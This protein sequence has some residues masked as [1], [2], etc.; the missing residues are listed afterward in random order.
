MSKVVYSRTAIQG[1]ID[2]YYSGDFYL[3][4]SG[5]GT[6]ASFYDQER[7]TTIAIAGIG[8]E[9]NSSSGMFTAG[10]VTQLVLNDAEGDKLVTVDGSYKAA[11]LSAAESSS[12]ADFVRVLFAHRDQITGSNGDD[13]LMGFGGK[14][15]I[16]GGRGNDYLDG[17]AGNGDVLNGGKGDDFFAFVAGNGNDTVQN[18]D[19]KGIKDGSEFYDH[20][21][22]YLLTDNYHI[23]KNTDGDAVVVLD[24]TN[25]TLTLEG[26]SKADLHGYNFFVSNPE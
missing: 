9:G 10:T 4:V 22:V 13:Y 14:D 1:P 6:S 23:T 7:G 17:G 25:E 12:F 2:Q 26:V 11:S 8:L 18:F 16:Q 19:A 21:T 20:D 24:D 5:D 3:E 15:I